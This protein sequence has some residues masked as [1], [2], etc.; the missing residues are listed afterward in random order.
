[1][2]HSVLQASRYIYVIPFKPVMFTVQL[3]NQSIAC[4]N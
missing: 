1:M 3:Q 2:T 4:L